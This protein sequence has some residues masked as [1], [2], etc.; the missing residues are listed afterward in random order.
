MHQTKFEGEPDELGT[1]AKPQ[2]SIDPIEV[3]V[4]GLAREAQLSGDLPRRATVRGKAED[5]PLPLRQE[6]E[7]AGLR[8]RRAE[9]GQARGDR[10]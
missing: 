10:R 2:L 1:V 3:G 4:D 7:G 5:L 9:G 6:V 8:A